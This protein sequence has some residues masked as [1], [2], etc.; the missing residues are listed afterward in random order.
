MTIQQL[1]A[2]ETEKNMKYPAVDYA[3]RERT[4]QSLREDD[5]GTME[6][7]RQLRIVDR[8]KLEDSQVFRMEAYREM[9]EKNKSTEKE[10]VK[11]EDRQDDRLRKQY[12]ENQYLTELFIRGRYVDLMA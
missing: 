2:A 10:L 5:R 9:V 7:H 1:A 8:S 12:R 4:Q 6:Y 3:T 11:L